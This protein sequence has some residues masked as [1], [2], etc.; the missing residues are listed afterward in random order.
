[1]KFYEEIKEHTTE[2]ANGN[3][4]TDTTKTTK[5]ILKSE[6][7][8][9][10]KVY[11]QMYCE[12]SGIP[13]KWRHLFMTLACR[14]SYA[15]PK[16]PNGGQTVYTVGSAGQAI[17][18][19]CGWKNKDTLY[20]GLQALCECNAI[21][22]IGRGEYQINPQY[23]G[24][25]GWHY[26]AKAEQGGIADLIATFS[27]ADKTVKTDIIWAS[28]DKNIIGN[29]DE[30]V[31]SRSTTSPKPKKNVGDVPTIKGKTRRKKEVTA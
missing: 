5:A 4:I 7:P 27:F 17:I 24:R 8:D 29:A 22:K 11:T 2:D 19:E 18:E 23:A 10:I 13:D 16:A 31:A 3:L 25:G 28:S 12:F 6:E 14:M 21:R 30:V 1:M 26:N 15:N 9:Y 20:R